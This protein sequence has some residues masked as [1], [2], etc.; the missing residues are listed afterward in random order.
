MFTFAFLCIIMNI[1]LFE[2]DF[3]M[4]TIASK[5][6]LGQMFERLESVYPEMIEVRR[7]FHMHP[8][9]SFKEVRTPRIIADHLKSL[10]LETYENVGTSGVVGILRGA[11]PGPTVG[12]RA[13]FDA[14]PM[15]DEKDAPYK[16]TVEGVTH[17]CGHDIHTTALMM[18][19]R[20]LVKYK[21]QLHGNVV[22]I[23]QHA[24][25]EPPGGASEIIAS[26]LLKDVDFIYGAHVWDEGVLGEVGFTEGYAMGAGDNF[27]IH[28]HG[29]GGHGARP[30]TSVDTLVAGCQLVGNLQNIV[31]R[32][33][34]PQK[35]GVVTVGTIRSGDS[36]NVIPSKAYIAGTS[37]CYD[38]ETKMAMRES[39][40]HISKTTAEQFG[41]TAEVIFAEGYDAVYNH[42][43]ETRNL[44]TL[45]GSHVPELKVL[46]KAP[47][48]T[49]E[50]F[51]DYLKVIPGTLLFVG[52]Q[53]D[54][55]KPKYTLHHPKFDPDE[56]SM[57]NIG[58]VFLTA[59]S[60]HLLGL[61]GAHEQ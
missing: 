51:A 43:H 6:L 2:G 45:I 41:A 58:K 17:A 21:D 55:S 33:L 29:D 49:A 47:A 7:D 25:E 34:D 48:L 40:E 3:I 50:D 53:T 23:H 13:D 14:L 22:F 59:V 36:Y 15:N 57:V 16:S 4:E 30:H 31:S 37:R 20:V 61:E 46:D 52:A 26:G 19:E 12:L 27:E 56:R 10:G 28:L 8:E 9:L 44:K 1:I 32:R 42:I 18:L 11:H 5:E 39:I 54:D 35:S 60:H 38:N 24:E